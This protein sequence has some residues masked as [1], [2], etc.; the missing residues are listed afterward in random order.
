MRK[1]RYFLQ[2]IVVMATL[3]L[4]SA[5]A[6]AQD[7]R[8]YKGM[9]NAGWIFLSTDTSI[10]ALTIHG[11]QFNKY[12][13]AGAGAGINYYSV[14]YDDSK[15]N[16]NA[17]YIPVFADVRGYLPLSGKFTPYA[18]AKIGA[19]VACGSNGSS[20]VYLAPEIGC[21]YFFS[22]KVGINVALEYILQRKD[23]IA[24]ADSWRLHRE[25]IGGL[26]LKVGVEF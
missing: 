12:L 26:C 9:V 15:Y 7:Y 23:N 8:G 16:E 6:N 19:M 5:S 22:N 4:L 2:T 10:E 24:P 21:A 14:R 18:E 11:Y 25:D 17:T 3:M 13:F 1:L 20:G